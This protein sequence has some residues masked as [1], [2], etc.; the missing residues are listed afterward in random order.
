MVIIVTQ[1]YCIQ[2]KNAIA[3]DTRSLIVTSLALSIINYCFI[4]W[5]SCGKTQMNRVQKLQNFAAKIISGNGRKY[6]H[7]T[8][9]IQ[10]LVG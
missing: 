5:G 1:S 9:F 3:K 7:A 6:D 2:I 10:K 4:I 8:P